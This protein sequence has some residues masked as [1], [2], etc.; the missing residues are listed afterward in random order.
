MLTVTS[1]PTPAAFLCA[2]Q[3]ALEQ[4]EAAHCL[5]LGLALQFDRHPERLQVLPILKTVR[6]EHGLRLA[7]LQTPPGNLLIAGFDGDLAP[8]CQSLA[9]DFAN[10]Q[11][12]L[13]GALAPE[14]IAQAFGQSYAQFT[15]HEKRLG[16]RMYLC[17]LERVLSAP[18]ASGR[19]RLATP[20]ELDLAT[21]WIHH[22]KLDTGQQSTLPEARQAGEM[23]IQDQNIY[24]WDTGRPVAMARPTRRT[25]HGISIGQVYTPPEERNRGYA[26]AL[27]GALSRKLLGEGNRYVGLFVD[28]DNTPAIR[29]YHKVGFQ[30]IEEYAEVSFTNI[31]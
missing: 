27:T 24:F 15:N 4:D 28:T 18:S 10:R 29:A 19:L 5:V 1:Y 14:P 6:D 11:Q 13:T 12:P 9:E 20:D 16:D 8:A 7:A 23:N 3:A 31:R 21:A 17:T 22:F 30:V 26:T 2:A 25:P